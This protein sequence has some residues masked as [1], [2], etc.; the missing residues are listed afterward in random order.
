[1]IYEVQEEQA[2]VIEDFAKLLPDDRKRQKDQLNRIATTTKYQC[3]E[4]KALSKKADGTH[5]AISHLQMNKY[6]LAVQLI[7]AAQSTPRIEAE[8]S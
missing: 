4:I 3:S 2:R 1:M 6:L 5:K 8:A 7:L